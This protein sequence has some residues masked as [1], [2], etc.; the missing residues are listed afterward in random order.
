MSWFKKKSSNDLRCSRCQK[1]LKPVQPGIPEVPKDHPNYRLL[2]VYGDLMQEG[3]MRV[4]DR[5][6]AF[7]CTTCGRVVCQAHTKP[8]PMTAAYGVDLCAFCGS[9]V[10]PVE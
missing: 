8:Q 9:P 7:K 4:V 2:E 10:Q 6:T 3:I 5:D 1:P